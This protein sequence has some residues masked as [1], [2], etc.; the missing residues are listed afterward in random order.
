MTRLLSMP[1]SE[2]PAADQAMWQELTALGGPL[3]EKGQLSHLRPISQNNLKQRYGFW[4]EWLHRREPEVLIEHPAPRAT[5]ERLRAWVN[6]NNHQ[7][8]MT[9]RTNLDSI[10][11]ILRAAAPEQ[12]W[13]NQYRLRQAL[14]NLAGDGQATRKFGRVLSS[15][16]LLDVGFELAGPRADAATTELEVNKRRR[17]GAMIAF[18]SLI[19]LR[20]RS[21]AELR[22]GSSVLVDEYRIRIALSGEMTKNHIP[23]ET[24]VPDVIVPLLRRYID[25][26]RP[27][28]MQRRDADHAHL[29]V[30]ENGKR[31][32]LV[33]LSRRIGNLTQALT[34]ARV[35]PHLFRDA[36]ASTLAR[37]SPESARL[38]RP[39]LAHAGFGTAERHYIQ[40]Q[41]VETGRQYAAVLGK[42]RKEP[43]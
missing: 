14:Q 39:L 33:Y 26:V 31:F 17:D 5:P 21:F 42:L 23:W 43:T 20:L 37:I 12:N 16:V 3:D 19:P 34:G 13:A 7:A 41:T 40:A 2:W 22:L 35:S 6:A 29:W 15:R 30:G 18:L 32:E 25:E 24:D 9:L 28:L 38:I 10:L 1:I 11:R 4:L 36:A 27:W 8:A